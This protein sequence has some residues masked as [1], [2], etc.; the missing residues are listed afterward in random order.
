MDSKLNKVLKGL[1]QGTVATQAWLEK[2]G[3]YRQLARRYLSSGWLEHFGRG[4]FIRA[5]DSVDW[6]GAVHA[7]HE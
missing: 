7:L 6:L 1:P 3:V 4:A 2:L 5:G